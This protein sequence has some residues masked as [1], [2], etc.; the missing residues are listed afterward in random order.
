MDYGTQIDRLFC[1]L[2][3]LKIVDGHQ[4]DLYAIN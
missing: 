3:I 1:M 2:K 4:S